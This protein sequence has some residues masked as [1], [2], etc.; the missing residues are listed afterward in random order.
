MLPLERKRKIEELITERKTM[1]ISELSE[2]M[3]VSEM[4]VH[5]DIKPLIAEGFIT[6]TFGGITLTLEPEKKV[7]KTDTCNFC[8]GDLNDR[9][10]YRIFLKENKTVTACCAHCG[11]LKYRELKRD[12]TQAICRDFL[13]QTT[14]SASRAWYVIDTLLPVGCCKPQVLTF[15]EE[16]YA[17]RFVT[18][19]GGEVYRFEDILD[20]V[21]ERMQHG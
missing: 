21:Y 12:V 11:V 16:E 4:T 3:D 9:L 14:I 10:I 5:R 2:E 20:V 13:L 15:E 19:F 6:K 1:K 18:G 8:E 17:N 7:E